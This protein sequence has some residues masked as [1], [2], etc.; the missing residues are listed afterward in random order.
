MGQ[1]L[2]IQ[3][4]ER[5]IVAGDLSGMAHSVASLHETWGNLSDYEQQKVLKL[6][7]IF[8]SFVYSKMEV[9]Q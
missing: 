7:A 4:F 1:S 5:H 8:L 3:D 2:Q 9:A 6:E